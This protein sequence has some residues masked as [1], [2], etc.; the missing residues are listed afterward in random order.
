MRVARHDIKPSPKDEVAHDVVVEV[1]RPLRH[2]ERLRPV[3]LTVG[4][5]QNDIPE[6]LH[7]LY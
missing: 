4:G 1:G 7:I 2:V 3:F 5:A 6:G